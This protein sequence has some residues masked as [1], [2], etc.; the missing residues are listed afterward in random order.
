MAYGEPKVI[1]ALSPVNA[2]RAV[3]SPNYPGE[4]TPGVLTLD[5]HGQGPNQFTDL[6]VD[7]FTFAGHREPTYFDDLYFRIHFMPGQINLGNVLSVQT[8]EI[9]VWNAYLSDK[10]MIGYQQPA[11][12]GINVSEPVLP[13]YTMAPLEELSYIVTVSTDGPPQ[14]SEEILWTIGGVEYSVPVTGQRVVVWPFGPNWDQPL[15]ESLEWKTDII[16]A[17]DGT[18]DRQPLRSKPRRKLGYWLTLNGNELNQFQNL[19]Y[20]W[21][22]RQYAVPIWW[23]KHVLQDQ[24]Q[25]NTDIIPVETTNRSF[26][27]GGLAILMTDT[28]TFEVFEVDAVNPDHLVARKP[29]EFTWDRLTRLYPLNL[30]TLPTNVP[31]ERLTS[32]VMTGNIEFLADP[33]ETDPFIPDEPAAET[34]DGY[35]VIYRKPN[36][37]TPVTYETEAGFDLLDHQIGAVQQ[38]QKPVHHKHIRKVNWLLKSKADIRDFRAMLGRREGQ[39]FPAYVPT[40]FHDF[41]VNQANGSGSSALRVKRSQYDSL[42]GERD[43]QRHVLIRLRDGTKILREIIGVSQPDA[44]TE[45]LSFSEALPVEV[46][47]Q[48]TLMVSLVHLCRLVQDGVTINYQ[49]D[50]V[51]KVEMTM[52]TVKA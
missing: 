1:T 13:P 47:P 7:T 11:A 17:F 28:Y 6:Q 3:P 42:V 32:K 34:L 31:T 19:L 21:Q 12:R 2:G 18:E 20:G 39:L 45:M 43:T 30:A 10:S 51:A 27:K 26:F 4:S 14:F 15:V 40:W 16:T 49:S 41:E 38:V 29:L 37:S 44:E 25:K 5:D 22:D 23:D 50:S 36:W 46:N 9:I 35:E 48:N 52:V 8:E 24:V 33:V